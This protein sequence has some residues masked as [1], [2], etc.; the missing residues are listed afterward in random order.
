MSDE[1]QGLSDSERWAKAQSAE[2]IKP[3]DLGVGSDAVA[4]NFVPM[5]EGYVPLIYSLQR[6]TTDLDFT[7]LAKIEED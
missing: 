4:N 6:D 5:T 1:K 7:E 3:A 2:A